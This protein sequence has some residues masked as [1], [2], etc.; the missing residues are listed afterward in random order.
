MVGARGTVAAILLFAVGAAWAQDHAAHAGGKPQPQRF[1]LGSSA[2]VDSSGTIWAVH[3]DSGR[4]AI[5]HTGGVGQSWSA[6]VVL[7]EAEERIEADGDARPKIAVGASNE[8]YVTWTH[9]LAKPYTGEIRF[10]RSIDGGKT[11][12]APV[13]VHRDRQQITH[14]F[15][16]VAVS[17]PG[18][19]FVAWI[20][21]RDAV[22]AKEKGEADYRGA[23]L[24]YAVSDD[25]GATF[26]GDFKVGDHSCECCRIALRPRS[27]GQMDAMWR[28]VFEPNVRDHALAVLAPD[29]TVTD[30]HR[31]TFDDWHIDACPH[32]G[33]SLVADGAGTLHSVWFALP[34]DEAGAFYGRLGDGRVDGQRKLGSAAAEHPDLAAAGDMLAVVWKEFD[35]ERTQLLAMTSSDRG[36]TWRDQVLASTGDASGHPQLLEAGAG[37]VVFWNTRAEGLTLTAVPR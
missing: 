11:F 28:H 8:L 31:V 19:V 27:D 36:Q 16:A 10:T 18:Q 20:D 14:R 4:V 3:V 34:S 29:G 23:A 15:D 25:R 22:L 5:R 26:R 6:P 9:P 12:S 17:Q 24:Y 37:F 2:A 13:T 30:L 7:S 32:H 1:A 33:P 21:R 35:G